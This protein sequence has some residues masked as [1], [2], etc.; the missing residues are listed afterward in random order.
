M[1]QEYDEVGWAEYA[2][3]QG[4]RRSEVWRYFLVRLQDPDDLRCKICGKIMKAS[5]S[6]STFRYHLDNIHGIKIGAA[7]KVPLRKDSGSGSGVI[8]AKDDKEEDYLRLTRF[9]D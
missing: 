8:A 7:P 2:E 9:T 6:P 4:R 5:P 3:F 1:M